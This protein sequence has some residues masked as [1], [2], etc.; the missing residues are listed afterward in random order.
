[1]PELGILADK[2]FKAE[3][4]DTIRQR[5]NFQK[6]KGTDKVTFRIADQFPVNSDRWHEWWRSYRGTIVPARDKADSSGSMRCFASGALVKPARV[7]SAKI[8]GL[9]GVGG[10]GM[11]DVLIGFKQESFCSYGLEQASN[12]AVSDNMASAYC[13]A[14]N[15]LIKRTG[16]KLAGTKIIHWFKGK[17]VPKDDDPLCWLEEGPEKEELNA[18]HRAQE[19]LSAIRK[20]ERPDLGDNYY[21]ALTLSGASGRVMVRDWIEGKFEGLAKNISDWFEDLSIVHRDGKGLAP[22]PKFLAV[23]GATVRELD[24]LPNPFVAKMW[25]VAVCDE[26]IPGVALARAF[27]RAKIDIL[28]DEPLNHAGIGLL[29]A[30]HVRNNRIKG[31]NPMAEDIKPYL[32]ESHPHPAYQCGRLMAVL[33]KLQKSALGDVGAGIVQRYYAAASSTPALV[34]GRLTRTS[35]AHLHKLEAGL[36]SWYENI[37]AG[38]WGQI[39]DSVPAT[40]TLEE[41]TLFALGYYQQMAHKE[42]KTSEKEN[43][44]KEA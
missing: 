17:E 42:T 33:A 10:L 14:L 18:Q 37:I 9:A 5:L 8:T 41:Q 22:S 44:T 35:Q 31:G 15:D 25:R 19:L 23:L 13:A 43:K 29:K 30:Y 4:L 24:E 26:G 20:G 32:N 12:A 34:L 27:G 2:V 28:K 6:A 16:Q 36:A 11:G 40:L 3:V 21:Y 39:K 7:H 38:I 1:M